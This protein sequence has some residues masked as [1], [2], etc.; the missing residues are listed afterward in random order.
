M[1]DCSTC[2]YEELKLSDPIC[3]TCKVVNGN[4]FTGWKAVPETTTI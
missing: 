4:I 1:S 2:R 3:K